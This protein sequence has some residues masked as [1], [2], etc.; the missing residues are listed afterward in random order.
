MGIPHPIG[1]QKVFCWSGLY[2]YIYIYISPRSFSSLSLQPQET[3]IHSSCLSQTLSDWPLF[4]PHVSA[5]IIERPCRT[6]VHV[7]SARMTFIYPCARECMYT[8]ICVYNVLTT[9]MLVKFGTCT[10]VV[11]DL[12]VI[13][14]GTYILWQ[15]YQCN[16][17]SNSS[18]NT[19]LRRRC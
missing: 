6:Q 19:P 2:I 14:A 8:N 9:T 5:S 15:L 11:Q 12:S 16:I 4:T 18:T 13:N 3:C 10:W 1:N 17:F 7:Y